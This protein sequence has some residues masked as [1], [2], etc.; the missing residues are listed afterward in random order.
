VQGALRDDIGY[1]RGCELRVC[2]AR[3][4]LTQAE[5]W[6]DGHYI[7]LADHG[8]SLPPGGVPLLV[9][10]Q[11]GTIKAQTELPAKANQVAW[12]PMSNRIVTGDINRTF[13]RW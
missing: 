6:E 12:S 3:R 8:L 5:G 11:S 9:V 13:W 4:R 2:Q 7:A 1:G 10:I